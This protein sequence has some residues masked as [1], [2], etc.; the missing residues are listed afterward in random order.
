MHGSDLNFQAAASGHGVWSWDFDDG[1]VRQPECLIG[2]AVAA[3][4][5][6]VANRLALR[7]A[8]GV[9]DD[10]RKPRRH[11]VAVFLQANPEPVKRV[12]HIP[13]DVFFDRRTGRWEVHVAAAS[14]GS[15]VVLV[16]S[17]GVPVAAIPKFQHE[18]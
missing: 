5:D 12:L 15:A 3:A 13:E 6:L 4:D 18:G 2:A 16:H 7:G 17:D 1:R 8:D 10:R 11:V 14:E 9:R